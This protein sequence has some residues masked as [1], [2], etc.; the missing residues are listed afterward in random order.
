MKSL[1]ELIVSRV[2]GLVN[3]PHIEIQ[4]RVGPRQ[5]LRW[6]IKLKIIYCQAANALQLFNFIRADLHSHRPKPP[7][8]PGFSASGPSTS[9]DPIEATEP[10]FPKSLYLIQPLF[11]TYELNPV[12]FTAQSSVPIP[13]G[14]DLDAWISVPP[15]QEAVPAAEEFG[16]RKV[17]KGKKGKGKEVNDS[18]PKS[19]KKRHKEEGNGD[20]L[21]PAEPEIETPEEQAERAR[22]RYSCRRMNFWTLTLL[23]FCLAQSRATRTAAG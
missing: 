17:K 6:S 12:A 3:S 5:C 11:S 18:K 16:E 4:E 22:V 19:A 10:R 7:T 13:D 15:P 23:S 8:T 21:T 1:V 9:F 14:L 2:S 20:F